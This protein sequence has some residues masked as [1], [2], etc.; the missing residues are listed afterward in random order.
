MNG[1][2]SRVATGSGASEVPVASGAGLR[3]RLEAGQE[4]R[5]AA[6]MQQTLES[7]LGDLHSILEAG[8]HEIRQSS[9]QAEVRLQRVLERGRA[10]LAY[11]VERME[12]LARRGRRIRIGLLL[13]CLGAG[14]LGGVLGALLALHRLG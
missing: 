1:R 3:A 4:E 12:R 8:A 10:D 6:L 9:E 7:V 14:A 5:G 11:E 2:G 13:L